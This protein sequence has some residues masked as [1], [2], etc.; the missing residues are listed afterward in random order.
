M[1]ELLVDRLRWP[2]ALVRE[3]AASQLGELIADGNVDAGNA[4][5]CW[6][7]RQELESLAAI[8]LLPFLYAAARKDTRPYTATELATGC[9]AGSVLSDLY[10]REFDPSHT[11]NT[12]HIRHS[13][14]RRPVRRAGGKLLS[15]NDHT[16]QDVLRDRLHRIEA[17]FDVPIVAQFDFE[18][19]ALEERHGRSPAQ[20]FQEAGS[21]SQ[22]FRPFWQPLSVEVCLSA[23]LRT[24]TWAAVTAQ[25]PNEVVL[26]LAGT[27][28][29][30]D[31]GLW[32]VKP[33][34]RPNWWPRL[35]NVS[36]ANVDTNVGAIMQAVRN[37]VEAWENS[38][39]VVL[40]ASGSISLTDLAQ[41][42]LEIRSFFQRPLG[43]ERPTSE[44]LFQH[45]RSTQAAIQQEPSILRFEGTIN[46]SAHSEYLADW[47]IV[48]C[49]ASTL[50]KATISWQSWRGERGIQIPS[51][52]LS[53]SEIHVVCT[54]VSINYQGEE[55][56]IARWSDW[57]KGISAIVQEDFNQQTGWLLTAPRGVV[58]KS[59]E[60][61]GMNLAWSWEI[62]SQFRQH[63]YERFATY[64]VCDD[65]GT[66]RVVR[67]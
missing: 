42:E 19:S 52:V 10:L 60:A 28:S 15:A 55:G 13:G 64:S 32:H 4:L 12:W 47:E 29:P 44:E 1:I 17:V 30:V 3:R 66:G 25:L 18:I 45:L 9:K 53:D 27:V 34:M 21:R 49:S 24:L 11:S 59:T 36:R 41:H 33:S 38:S 56:L 54:D 5:L 43:P 14:E 6:I 67:P 48:P 7:K 65:S 61:T 46:R 39:D 20:A 50:P 2:A 35:A 26:R 57:T 62:T 8:G 63:F 37:A 23:Y 58:D 51:Q 22:G 40:A 31:L 16:R